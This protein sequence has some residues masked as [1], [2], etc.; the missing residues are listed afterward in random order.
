MDR[1][2][3]DILSKE[4]KQPKYILHNSVD[5]KK[6]FCKRW[7]CDSV[8]VF[9]KVKLIHGM[10]WQDNGGLSEKSE[11]SASLLFV[12]FDLLTK[13]LV[14]VFAIMCKPT[15]AEF[16]KIYMFYLYFKE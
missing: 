12:P 2:Q 7:E 14:K 3:E 6:F 9:F 16:M 13:I 5:V 10:R 11:I 8:V 1:F 15:F 4:A